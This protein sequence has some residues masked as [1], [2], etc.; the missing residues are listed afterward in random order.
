M[1]SLKKPI[2]NCH[3]HIFT[4][5]AIPPWIAFKLIYIFLVPLSYVPLIFWLFRTYSLKLDFRFKKLIRS[6]NLIIGKLK[7][8]YLGLLFYYS[9][10]LILLSNFLALILTRFVKIIPIKKLVEWGKFIVEKVFEPT[11]LILNFSTLGTIGI[12]VL[13]TIIYPQFYSITFKILKTIFS[14][15]KYLPSKQTLEFVGRYLNIAHLA[16]YKLER[17]IYERLESQYPKGSY[18]VVLPMDMRYMGAGKPKE[19]Y[20]DQINTINKYMSS[21]SALYEGM[22][23]FVFVDPRRIRKEELGKNEKPFFTWYQKDD[24]VKLKDCLLRDL[25]EEDQNDPMTTGNFKG[26]KL[27]PALGYYPFDYDLLPLYVYCVQNDIPILTHCIQGTI[28]YRGKMNPLWQE[29]PVFENNDKEKL[30]TPAKSN[31]EVQLNF[32]HPL[33][34]LVLLEDKLLFKWLNKCE[35]KEIK[36]LFKYDEQNEKMTQNSLSKLKINLAHYGGREEWQKYNEDERGNYSKALIKDPLHGIKFLYDR[37]DN[38][39]EGKLTEV[40]KTVDWYSIISSMMLQYDG[41]YADISYILHSE[42]IYPTLISTL[43][44]DKLNKKVLYGTDF[45]V[46]RNHNSERELF[47]KLISTIPTKFVNRICYYNPRTY[48]SNVDIKD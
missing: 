29:H 7:S 14:P 40:W 45:F 17:Q 34:F 36:S 13:F 37:N 28:F 27:Y 42:T 39:S 2:I 20:R 8:N 31:Y 22:I 33:N 9:T 4:Y 12:L 48:L 6:R 43:Q 26:I 19:D 15:L 18:F 47:S 46:V 23:P 35:S 16:K 30:Q 21:G 11:H 25:L 10:L 3:T 24:K 1:D 41:V 44:N 32:T 38:Y 5:R